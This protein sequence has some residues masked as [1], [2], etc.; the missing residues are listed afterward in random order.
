MNESNKQMERTVP[1]SI[2]AEYQDDV[3]IAQSRVNKLPR[4]SRRASFK[5][6]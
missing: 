5:F 6:G 2:V 1:S 3:R 4:A